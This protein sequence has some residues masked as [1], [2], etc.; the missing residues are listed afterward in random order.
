MS[1][2]GVIR[3]LLDE[4][5]CDYHFTSRFL[6]FLLARKL[7]CSGSVKVFK[8]GEEGVKYQ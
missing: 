5:V 6:Y 2:S 8:I 7:D 4:A 3:P 1:M